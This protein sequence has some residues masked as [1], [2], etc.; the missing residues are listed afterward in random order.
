MEGDHCCYDSYRTPRM[1]MQ[2]IELGLISGSSRKPYEA[3]RLTQLISVHI[4]L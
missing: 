3:I 1:L 4:S 2:P